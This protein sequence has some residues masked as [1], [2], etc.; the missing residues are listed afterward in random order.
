MNFLW[1]GIYDSWVPFRGCIFK[2]ISEFQRRPPCIWIPTAQN[3][4]Y[5]KVAYFGDSRFCVQ[6][7]PFINENIK[8]QTNQITGPRSY[9]HSL[10]CLSYMWNRYNL[11]LP[12]CLSLSKK[13][14]CWMNDWIDIRIN[15]KDLF[16]FFFFF[17]FAI[18]SP[19]F[20][21]FES[22]KNSKHWA[23]FCMFLNISFF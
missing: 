14:I 10:G 8:V 18:W 15:W 3:N 20:M 5:A 23:L 7:P 9:I 12:M 19:N 1:G 22:N 13:S 16:F 6:W 4:H 17:F 21:S 2:Q 11:Y